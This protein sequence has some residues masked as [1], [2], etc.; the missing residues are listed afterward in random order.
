M[1]EWSNFFSASASASAALAGLVFVALSVNLQRIIEYPHLPGRAGAA[2]G[3]LIVILVSS[4]AMLAPQPMVAR[5][6]EITAFGA[7]GWVLEARLSF[8]ATPDVKRPRYAPWV[9]TILGQ[10]QMLPFIAGGILLMMESGYGPRWVAGGAIAV[11]IFSAVSAWVLLI[12]IV[13]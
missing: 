2:I 8:H 4:M 6:V 12:E 3:G 7:A 1:S 11:F 9:S 10:V 5:G 13:R